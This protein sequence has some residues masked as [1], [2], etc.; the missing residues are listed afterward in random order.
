[1]C[2]KAFWV[3]FS[4]CED[5]VL[6]RQC[7]EK[8]F[9]FLLLWC[10][11]VTLREILPK[12]KPCSLLRQG[13]PVY[14]CILQRKTFVS[15]IQSSLGIFQMRRRFPPEGICLNFCYLLPSKDHK[16]SILTQEAG[17]TVQHSRANTDL[18]EDQSLV[19]SEYECLYLQFQGL[20]CPLLAFTDTRHPPCSHHRK[21][22][23]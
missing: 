10:V 16:I 23:I 15:L 4:T 6:T 20:W 13:L 17:K 2:L 21:L 19:P 9:H 1:M 22:Y 12:R 14:H 5:M 8:L 11:S 3:C 7:H 18:T